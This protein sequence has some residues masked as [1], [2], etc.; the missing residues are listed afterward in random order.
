MTVDF[1][2]K[3]KMMF[4]L[5]EFKRHNKPL[6]RRICF[7]FR[8]KM[9]LHDGLYYAA[10]ILAGLLLQIPVYI[11]IAKLHSKSAQVAVDDLDDGIGSNKN[12][13]EVVTPLI[14]LS[15]FFLAVLVLQLIDLVKVI[16]DHGLQVWH[17]DNLGIGCQ[18]IALHSCILASLIHLRTYIKAQE[19]A[20]GFYSDDSGLDFFDVFHPLLVL[21]ILFLVKVVCCR[22]DTT[23]ELCIITACMY[24]IVYIGFCIFD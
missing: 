24:S 14:W 7:D 11:S 10:V 1:A 6:C 12:Y 15:V 21:S 5:E 16:L 17:R 4:S 13:Y 3:K 9:I 8:Q 2:D 19:E 22:S 18:Q 20:D 23:A